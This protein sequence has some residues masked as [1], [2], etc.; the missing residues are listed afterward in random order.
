MCHLYG[1]GDGTNNADSAP[2]AHPTDIPLQKTL[3]SLPLVRS[4]LPS[5]PAAI[6]PA[7]LPSHKCEQANEH[8][9]GSEKQ[10]PLQLRSEIQ[11]EPL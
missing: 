8:F 10:A 7:Q 9:V 2:S 6:A 1:A 11:R 3:V 4:A 5:S